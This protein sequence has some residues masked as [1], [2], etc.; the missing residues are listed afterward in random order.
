MKDID[1]RLIRPDGMQE[2]LVVH[3][4]AVAT[5]PEHSNAGSL[6]LGTLHPELAPPLQGTAVESG[7]WRRYIQ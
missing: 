4:A 3:T 2:A 5:T 1:Q 6:P 7:V